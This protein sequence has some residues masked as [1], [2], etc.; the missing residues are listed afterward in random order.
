M[1]IT[2]EHVPSGSFPKNP[3]IPAHFPCAG[4]TMVASGDNDPALQ[5]NAFVTL[6]MRISVKGGIVAL[7]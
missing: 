2:Q 5:S 3:I 6:I 1:R 4:T 7:C